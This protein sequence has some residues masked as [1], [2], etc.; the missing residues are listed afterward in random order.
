[1]F[2]LSIH[3]EALTIL[4]VT[5]AVENKGARS[6]QNIMLLLPQQYA[7]SRSVLSEPCY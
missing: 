4:A 7:I 6:M 3:I 1:M 5:G 2:L